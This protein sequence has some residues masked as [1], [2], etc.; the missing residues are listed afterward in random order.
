[1]L[2]NNAKISRECL[3]FYVTAFI[4]M[5]TLCR[6]VLFVSVLF[7][8]LFHWVSCARV[9]LSVNLR[10]NGGTA[11]ARYAHIKRCMDGFYNMI[12]TIS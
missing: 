2:F 3:L 1:M 10:I 11:G 8:E 6:P 12:H 5:D 4:N 7:S 9:I